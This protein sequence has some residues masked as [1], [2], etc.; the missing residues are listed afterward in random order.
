[1]HHQRITDVLASCRYSQQAVATRWASLSSYMLPRVY[2]RIFKSGF[3][4][5][6]IAMSGCADMYNL[7]TIEH[8]FVVATHDRFIFEFNF[9]LTSRLI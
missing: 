2:E 3:T 8:C 7:Y 9:T 4:Y 1:M 6:L 5:L